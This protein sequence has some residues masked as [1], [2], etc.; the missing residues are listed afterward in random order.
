MLPVLILIQSHDLNCSKYLRW[1]SC[2]ANECSSSKYSHKFNIKIIKNNRKRA[3]IFSKQ[4]KNNC[5]SLI[6]QTD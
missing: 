4:G 1:L 3:H 2:Q 5:L 6:D